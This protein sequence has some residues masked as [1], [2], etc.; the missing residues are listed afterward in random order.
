MVAPP[1]YPLPPHG[2]GGIELV[3]SLLA[4]GLRDRGHRVVLFGA[5]D[6]TDEVVGLAPASWRED[7]GYVH[8]QG[9]RDV[10]YAARVLN[11][12]TDDI[13]HVDLIHDHAGLSM[14]ATAHAGHV[15]PVL[16]TVHGP[17][18]EALATA[19]ASLTKDTALVA[20]SDSQREPAP[21][22]PWIATVPNAVDLDS[23]M[24]LPAADKEDY[25]LV[26]ARICPDKGQHTAIEVAKRSGMR[27]V[28]AGKID[29]GHE[30]Y[31]R[32]RVAPHID[33]TSVRWIKNVAGAEKAE[34]LAK[35]R[36]LLAPI[37]WAEPFGLSMVEAMACGTP[38]IAFRLGSVPELVTHGATGFIVDT[39]D[40]MV[41]AV[42]AISTIDPARC[43]LMARDRFSAS[44][45]V[46][47]YLV[48]YR[49]LL[50]THTSLGG[51]R[52]SDTG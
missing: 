42:G 11:H 52:V 40:E 29:P 44:A 22:L 12:L 28:L 34:L 13:D 45:M 23:L 4:N 27:L 26:L 17:V 32:A 47:G 6:S 31:F 9:L 15:A 8:N 48:A 36:A 50:A 1:W 7:L 41:S 39:V 33:G 51:S 46:N 35:A 30:E 43:S 5:D 3:V 18:T 37:T 2:Y 24:F 21:W 16:H 49:R 10:T 20:I 19:L 14:L 25:L 38:T